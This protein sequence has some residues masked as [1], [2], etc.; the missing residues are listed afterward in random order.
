MKRISKESLL[1]TDEWFKPR[2]LGN[3]QSERKKKQF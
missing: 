2:D 1:F 3:L